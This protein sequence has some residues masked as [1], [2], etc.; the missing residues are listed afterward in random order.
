MATHVCENLRC[1]SRRGHH[2]CLITLL[3]AGA[4]IRGADIQD[5]DSWTPLHWAVFYKEEKCIMTLLDRG[6]DVNEKN[7]FGQT[8]LD[9]ANDKI[10][11][12]IEKYYEYPIKEPCEL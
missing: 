9:I 1:A 8:P 6:A 12:F 4:D 3:N 2:D 10:K 5:N 11:Q 7:R